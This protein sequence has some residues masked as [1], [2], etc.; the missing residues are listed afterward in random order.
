MSTC[1]CSVAVAL[2]EG[3]LVATSDLRAPGAVLFTLLA[4]S[5]AAVGRALRTRACVFAHRPPGETSGLDDLDAAHAARG[6]NIIC[7]VPIHSAQ[8]AAG[9]DGLPV[10]QVGSIWVPEYGPVARGS[11][12]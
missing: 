1:T 3:M 10:C 9:G 12:V 8:H 7:C 6:C 4:A 2:P 11:P 5:R